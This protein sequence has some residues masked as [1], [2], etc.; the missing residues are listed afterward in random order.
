MNTKESVNHEGIWKPTSTRE[1]LANTPVCSVCNG[2]GI[3]HPGASCKTC[4]GSGHIMSDR[5]Q[6]LFSKLCE[7]EYYDDLDRQEEDQSTDDI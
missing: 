2:E 4:H 6:K 1:I 5:L 3:S 7:K